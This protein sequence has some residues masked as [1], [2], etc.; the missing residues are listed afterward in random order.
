MLSLDQKKKP[1]FLLESGGQRDQTLLPGPKRRHG[2]R[3][4]FP[5]LHASH[6]EQTAAAIQLSDREGSQTGYQ[7]KLVFQSGKN[8]LKISLNLKDH[9]EVARQKLTNRRQY[10]DIC[11]SFILRKPFLYIAINKK[12]KFNGARCPFST[13]LRLQGDHHCACAQKWCPFS[14]FPRAFKQTKKLRLQK[15]R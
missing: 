14:Y 4:P 2:L 12:V 8:G 5:L 10:L 7:V 1:V 11:P 9:N 15:Q 13:F 3:C 6:P